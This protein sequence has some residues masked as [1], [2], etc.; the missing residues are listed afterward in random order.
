MYEYKTLDNGIRI[1]A[2]KIPHLRSVSIGVWIGNGSR[3]EDKNIN[4]ISHFIEHM[5][6]KGTQKRSA[7]DIAYTI[8]SVGGMINAFTARE[9]TCFYTK[10]L[11]AHAPLAMDVLSDMLFSSLLKNE[12]IEL[13][14]NVIY[15]E[16]GMYE[17]SPE[18]L[19][20]DIASEAVWGDTPLGRTV[21]GTKESLANINSDI[22]RDYIKTHYTSKNIIISVAGNYNDG[23]F[24]MAQKYF[25][26][27]KL[28]DKAPHMEKC[29]YVPK[30]IV[31]EKDVEQVQL[32]ASFNGIDVYDESVMPLLVFNNIFGSGMSSR[33][34]QNIREKYGLVYS[35]G[36]GHCAY[37]DCGTFDI[38]AAMNV[39]NLKNVCSL[40]CEEI[41]RVKTEKI[42]EDE[43]EASKRQLKG[44][45]ILSAE[46]TSARMQ[47]AGRS[48]LLNKP[49][50]TQDEMLS[51]IDDVTTDDVAKIIDRIFDKSALCIT[52]LGP[53]N[54]VDGL[55][56][57]LV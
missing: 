5:L 34:F 56:D 17:D 28:I 7:K 9:Y 23:F 37:I 51:K 16:I 41:N 4:G 15:E 18:D 27:Q 29:F 32:V 42:S 3:H 30:S 20:F 57:E 31:R 6:F 50:Y 55:F 33:L 38:S 13:E 2:E 46:S 1:I 14:R 11:D 24:E 26:T 22:M 48:L 54:S 45:Y 35:I 43:V 39:D 53:V 44:S 12:D 52:A 47:G 40:I 49:I 21:L 10:T 36:A 8:D 19:V 25:G